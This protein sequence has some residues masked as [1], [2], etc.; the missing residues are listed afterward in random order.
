MNEQEH[1]QMNETQQIGVKAPAPQN[2]MAMPPVTLLSDP[3]HGCMHPDVIPSLSKRLNGAFNGPAATPPL[4]PALGLREFTR[5]MM[6]Q[7][8]GEVRGSVKKK[9]LFLMK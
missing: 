7:K 8:R 5:A 6:R 1:E 3:A 4:P 2:K 9:P